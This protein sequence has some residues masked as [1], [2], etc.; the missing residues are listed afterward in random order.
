[1]LH[2]VVMAG[3][4]GTR[5][6]PESRKSRPKQLLKLVGA[7]TLIRQ[8]V[9]RLGPLIAAD[10]TLVVTSADLADAVADELP[11]VPTEN[12]VAEPCG[13]DTAACIGL[14]AHWL[15][16]GDPDA[17]MVVLPADH[18]IRPAQAFQQ[19]LAA[20]AGWIER[21]PEALV[22]LGAPPRH[23]ATGFGYIERGGALPKQNGVD[24]YEVNAFRE[25]PQLAVAEQFVAS[26]N[27]Y[28]N[29]GIFIWRAARILEALAQFAPQVHEA[30]GR[31]A[32]ALGTA[33]EQAT[34][35][36]VYPEV[37]RISIDHAVMEKAGGVF[38]LEAA[39]QWEDVGNWE[40]LARLEGSDAEGNCIT[41]QHCGLDTSEC[42]IRGQPGALVATVGVSNLIVVQTADCVLVADRNRQESFREL[43][44]LLRERGYE[45]FL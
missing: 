5:F 21:N 43:N 8:T 9:D 31:I 23:A 11:D 12:I 45:P 37:P 29:C 18:F 24:L 10:E 17:V 14:A 19:V 3:G 27:F 6:W 4:S 13:R 34:L 38:V 32:P 36:R 41:G 40:A 25:K 20:A 7:E 35:A 26:G 44:A 30:L 1:M 39:F 22:T 33:E 16:R 42:I 28:W 2:A 15:L